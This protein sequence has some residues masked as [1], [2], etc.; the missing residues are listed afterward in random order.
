MNNRGFATAASELIHPNYYSKEDRAEA[1]R[2][3]LDSG[4]SYREYEKL[5]GIPKST[6]C[7]FV[8]SPL[9]Y[10]NSTGAKKTKKTKNAPKPFKGKSTKVILEDL[11][12]RVGDM[13]SL[14]DDLSE[15]LLLND[16]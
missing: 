10:A 3:F 16:N 7:D 4:Y 13:Y 11:Y 1:V 8:H 12:D 14:L 15:E 2:D 6:L 9:A 5:T